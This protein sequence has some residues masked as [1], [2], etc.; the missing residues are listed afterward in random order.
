MGMNSMNEIPLGKSEELSFQAREEV[1]AS[2]KIE[3]ANEFV[4]TMNLDKLVF[5]EPYNSV[6][7]ERL[8]DFIYRFV[9]SIATLEQ[10][11][12]VFDDKS[13]PS[14]LNFDTIKEFVNQN[15]AKTYYERNNQADLDL[16]EANKDFKK[17]SKPL[18]T[19]KRSSVLVHR[20]GCIPRSWRESAKDG[21]FVE[22]ERKL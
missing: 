20:R 6:Q 10:L 22:F 19:K 16:E 18:N 5:T 3:N 14:S 15:A 12:K 4:M 1:D 2:Y 7:R 13:A 21:I 8:V 11:M 17:R 9:E